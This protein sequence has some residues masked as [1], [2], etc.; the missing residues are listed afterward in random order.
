MKSVMPSVS[1]PPLIPVTSSRDGSCWRV[2][3]ALVLREMATSFGRSPG[4]YIWAFLEPTVGIAVLVMLFSIG[5]RA[6]PLGSDFSLFYASGFLPFVMFQMTSNKVSQAINQSRPLLGYPRV[7]F[8]DTILAR[9]ILVVLT[10]A[11]V[12]I[13]ILVAIVV[14]FRPPEHLQV[15][16]IL[17]AYLVAAGLGFGVG[18][19]NCVLITRYVVW[20]SVWSVIMRPMVLVSGVIFLHE[21]VPQPYQ[22]WLLWNPLVHVT[23]QSR[24]GTYPFYDA[25]YVNLLYPI[26][27]ALVCAVLGLLILQACRRDL[28]EL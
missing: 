17:Y 20:Q 2:V 6:P 27:C 11:V 12:S 3:M 26:G 19:L 10:Q 16:T 13:V 23:G 22:D 14:L 1:P 5:F 21:M 15:G 24:K 4:G 25:D 7:T 28:L 8:I 18:C 9:F